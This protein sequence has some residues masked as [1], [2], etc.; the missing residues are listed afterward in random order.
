MARFLQ[1][2]STRFPDAING[3]LIVGKNKI[4]VHIMW[5]VSR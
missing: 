4:G 5:L 3:S 2:L 1:L